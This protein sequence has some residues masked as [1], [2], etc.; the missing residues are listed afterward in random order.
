[1]GNLDTP[2]PAAAPDTPDQPQPLRYV[3]FTPDGALDGCY[4]QV[5]PEE[6]AS[7]MLVIDEA[8]APAWVNY[9]ANEARD[10]VEPVPPKNPAEE[11]PAPVPQSVTRRQAR[12]A[13]LIAGLLD[14]VQ[15]A[16]DAIPDATQRRLAQIEW[17]DSLEFLRDRP[18]VIQIGA[19]LGLDAAGLD[20]MFVNAASL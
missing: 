15:L 19:A 13:L 8:L 14:D 4:L 18:L 3:T 10:S 1:M 16:I 17:E 6:H 7:R 20:Q 9:R 2:E 11:G 5:P 12:Q